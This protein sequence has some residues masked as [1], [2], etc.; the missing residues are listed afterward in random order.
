MPRPKISLISVESHKQEADELLIGSQ[1]LFYFSS[2]DKASYKV[3][4]SHEAAW[5][6]DT[7]QELI[8]TEH[9]PHQ[10]K[11]YVI[12]DLGDIYLFDA[13]VHSALNAGGPVQCAGWIS[14]YVKDAKTHLC[15]DNCSGHYTPSLV[16]FMS[17]LID[18]RTRHMVPHEFFIKINR[19]CKL[20]AGADLND[21]IKQF[22]TLETSENEAVK[23]SIAFLE[24]TIQFTYQHPEDLSCHTL[25]LSQQQCLNGPQSH[26]MIQL[27]Q[28]QLQVIAE[29]PLAGKNDLLNFFGSSSPDKNSCGITPT[30][31]A[32]SPDES[33]KISA[34][35][36]V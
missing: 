4:A 23:I 28:D 2:E 15:I 25:Q 32:S 35:S 7:S 5:R 6:Y 27:N 14:Y 16:Q 9:M 1:Q 33:M 20:N 17:V 24:D 10:Q 12:D 8:A 19:L 34:V 36:F 31:E 26:A 3:Q 21:F 11:M 22:L 18:L 30:S 13:L 29:A